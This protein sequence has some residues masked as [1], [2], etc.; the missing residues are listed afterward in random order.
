MS[1]TLVAP[2]LPAERAQ[3]RWRDWAA[4][5]AVLLLLYAG[6]FKADPLL[7]WV[8]ADLTVTGAVLTALGIG[9]VL[10]TTGEV[11]RGTLPVLA[12]WATF[13]PAAI[14]HAGNAYGTGK[15]LYL[16]TLTL[17]A[18]LGAVFLIRTPGRQEAWVVMQIGLGCAL[19]L[20]AYLTPPPVLPEGDVYRLA[21]DGSNAIGAGRAAGV[22]V[23]GCLVLALAGHRRRLPLLALG[24]AAAVP[25]FLAGSRGPVLAA[26]VAVAA[27]ALL[28]PA[29][30]V[31]R[32]ARVILIAAG[33]A[34]AWFWLR[35][36]VSGSTGRV[37]STLLAG[38]LQDSSSQTRLVLWHET[39]AV[40][41]G[42]PWGTGWGG[43]ASLPGPGLL[44]Q[45]GLEYPHNLLLEV[46]AEGGWLAGAAVIVFLWCALRRLR[47]CAL[48]PYPA[49]L[50][51]IAVFFTVNAMVSGDVNDQRAM[52][53]ALAVAWAVTGP[54]RAGASLT[55]NT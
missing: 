38:N 51:A 18:A 44:G 12:L 24:V 40:I 49:A 42:H 14:F 37:A 22:A 6:Y 19:A 15:T 27:V 54:R 13:I 11:P 47:S 35:A 16:F 23:A 30:G 28:A 55:G 3:S 26:A 53:A 1:V 39:W 17:L 9:T 34:A 50:F 33:G 5:G 36:D 48:S 41:A 21:L 52:W 29:S 8:P 2:V 43:L 20:G 4:P 46:T 45:P 25:L 10:V 7:S 31:T 32:S